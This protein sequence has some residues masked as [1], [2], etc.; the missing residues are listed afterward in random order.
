MLTRR[1]PLVALVAV[2]IGIGTSGCFASTA[3]PS[4]SVDAAS[5]SPSPLFASDEEALTAATEAYAAY[6][7]ASNS[8]GKN[9][10]KNTDEIARLTTEEALSDD[11]ATTQRY[12]DLAYV[13]IGDS[14]FDSI[15]IQSSDATSLTAY[16]CLDASQADLVDSSGTSVVNRDQPRRVPL[17]VEFASAGPGTS[18]LLV[19]RSEAWTGDNFC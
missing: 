18:D 7:E 13:Q 9:G 12:R 2:L 11:S 6:L 16:L 1:A 8:L 3:T 19:G 4:P 10:W 15:S 14:T 17:Q 5:P